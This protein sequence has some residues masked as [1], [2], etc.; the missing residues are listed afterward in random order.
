MVSQGAKANISGQKLEKLC[1][2]EFTSSNIKFISQVKFTDC[3]NNPRSKMDFYLSEFDCAVECKRQNVSG[4][5]DQKLPFVVEN[6][7]LFP[8]KKGLL[9]LDGEH[10]ENKQGIIQYLCSKQSEV[11]DWCFFYELGDWLR[12]Q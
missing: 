1:M 4:T 12:G 5:A 9:V 3:Y 6:L 10:Y 8:A 11:F 2:G 7:A